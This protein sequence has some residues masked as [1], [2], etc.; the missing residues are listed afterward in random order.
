MKYSEEFFEFINAYRE[1]SA[2]YRS[3]LLDVVFPPGSI[4]PP[5]MTVQA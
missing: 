3:G 5:L 2:Y 1:S 4:R